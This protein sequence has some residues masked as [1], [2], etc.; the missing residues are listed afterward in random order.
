[1]KSKNDNK[2]LAPPKAPLSEGGGGAESDAGGWN[3][4][5]CNA[6]G[7]NHT[8]REYNS[9]LNPA[10]RNLRKNATKQEQHLWYDFLKDFTPRFTRQRIIGNFIVDFFCAK[11]LLVVELD[12]AHHYTD[13]GMKYDR[14]RTAYMNTYGI[15]VLRF[16]NIEIDKKFAYVC[17]KIE[18]TVRGRQIIIA[19]GSTDFH[20]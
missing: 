1:M 3:A 11:A 15:V 16:E 17:G 18:S 9:T 13:E 10:A 4:A 14:A 19:S 5:D 2:H 6:K 7:W 8:H 12:G 20:K